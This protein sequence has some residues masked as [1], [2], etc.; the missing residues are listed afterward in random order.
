MQ[1]QRLLCNAAK[2]MSPAL[3]RWFATAMDKIGL[4]PA[5][6]HALWTLHGLGVFAIG[7]KG[8]SLP[9]TPTSPRGGGDSSALG[10]I[11]TLPCCEANLPP[12]PGERA[13]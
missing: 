12:S 8:R 2:P 7:V 11:G 5:A 10:Q 13:E 3:C 4:S 1:A 6:I 9:L